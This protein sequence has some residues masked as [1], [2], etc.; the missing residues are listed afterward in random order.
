VPCVDV[1]ET[2]LLPIKLP[3][4]ETALADAAGAVLAHMRRAKRLV[5]M[6][7]SEMSRFNLEE[8]LQRC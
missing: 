3:V 1:P 5:F 6:G 8:N 4:T 7:S 2:P